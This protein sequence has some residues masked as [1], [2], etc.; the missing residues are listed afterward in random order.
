MKAKFIKIASDLQ[1]GKITDAQ[2]QKI[3]VGLLLSAGALPTDDENYN[4]AKKY[5]Q[6]MSDQHNH[7]YN[8]AFCGYRNCY[9]ELIKIVNEPPNPTFLEGAVLNQTE[10]LTK[11][12]RHLCDIAVIDNQY[13]TEYDIKTIPKTFRL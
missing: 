2:A 6:M 5:A 12:Y 8:S 11:F 1:Q 7:H 13:T 9:N 4:M 10:L 3:L